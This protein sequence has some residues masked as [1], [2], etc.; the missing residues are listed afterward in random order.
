MTC[1]RCGRLLNRATGR[2]VCEDYGGAAPPP[3]AVTHPPAGAD[4]PDASAISVAAAEPMS[5]AAVMAVLDLSDRPVKAE[6]PKPPPPPAPVEPP[7]PPRAPGAPVA[8]IRSAKAG[9]RKTDAVVYDGMLVLASR[10]APEHLLAPQLAAQ[11]AGSRRLDGD[12]VDD[13][14]VREDAMGGK[15]RI[16]LRSGEVVSLSWPGRKNRGASVENLL[17][18]AFP[19]KVDQGSSELG[20]RA[21]RAVA[22]VGAAILV[23]AGLFVGLS[24]LLQGDPASEAPPAPPPTLAPAE[25]TARDELTAACPPW[26]A[27]AA[28]VPAGDRPDPAQLRP[29]VEG[30]RGRFEAAAATGADP[31]Y[32]AARDEVIYLQDYAGRT[33]EAA[34]MESISRVSWA[35]RTVSAACARAVS[36]P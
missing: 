23:L 18:H 19:G 29:V 20:A 1:D 32:A 26:Q 27:F 6:R 16:H 31:S 35:M 11:D 14:V 25:Q 17:A 13:V 7:P 12:L 34:R 10:G 5:A 21:V 36:A 4:A 30:I 33:A 8:V 22:A 9:R 2:C 28:A 15:A 24:A 3:V